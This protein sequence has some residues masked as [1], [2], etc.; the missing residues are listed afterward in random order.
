MP[1]SSITETTR[2]VIGQL[3]TTM[4]AGDLPALL[5]LLDADVVWDVPGD[6]QHVPW[7]GRRTIDDVPAFFTAMAEHV[8]RERFD[9]ERIVVDGPNG[10][11]IGDAGLSLIATGE[12]VGG[13]FA[14]DIGVNAEEKITRFY[15]FEDS[16]TLAAAVRPQLR[17]HPGEASPT[18]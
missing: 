18:L 1:D 13:K 11:I 17:D 3:L 6:S 4:G 5:T 12:S 8:V 15:M 2:S 7:L 10:V 16:W 9:V 14:I